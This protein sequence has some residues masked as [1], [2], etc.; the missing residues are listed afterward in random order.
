MRGNPE[1]DPG[2]TRVPSALQKR[3]AARIVEEARAAAKAAAPD[4]LSE[5]GLARRLGVSRTPV[6]AALEWLRTQQLMRR[7]D[8]G[9]W[10]LAPAAGR[11]HAPA[12][13]APPPEQTDQLFVAIA[14]DRVEERLAAEVSEADLMRRYDVPRAVV[15]KV[16]ARLAEVGLAERKRGHGWRF[17]SLAYD[18]A[19]RDESYAFRLLIEPA[20]LLAPAFAAAPA[21]LQAMRERHRE[22]MAAPWRETLSVALFDLNAEFHEGLAAA[23]GNRYLQMAMAQQNRLRRFVN[24]YWTEGPERV[25]VSCREHLEMIERIAAGDREVAAAL[26]RRHL[27]HASE[28]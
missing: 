2:P 24:V 23:S 19:A 11:R 16:L 17:R 12:L 22:M 25:Q 13:P 21:W 26:M 8:A 3:L 5:L 7:S 10:Q 18:R 28:L 14:R 27:Q 20:A 4:A 6:R 9:G 15:L 1:S